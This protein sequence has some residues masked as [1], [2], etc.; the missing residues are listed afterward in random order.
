MIRP[1]RYC[2]ELVVCF[3]TTSQRAGSLARAG[4]LGPPLHVI[5]AFTHDLGDFTMPQ[6]NKLGSARWIWNSGNTL[7]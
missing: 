3:R 5:R 1:L 6:R 4:G 2:T 7:T